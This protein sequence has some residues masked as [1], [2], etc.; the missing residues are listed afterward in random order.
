[1][2]DED[3]A[4]INDSLS[5]IAP[6]RRHRPKGHDKKAT[7]KDVRQDSRPRTMVKKTS[8]VK[9][10]SSS[11]EMDGIESVPDEVEGIKSPFKAVEG[12]KSED[13]EMSGIESVNDVESVSA[14][15]DNAPNPP[16]PGR[17]RQIAQ[18]QPARHV[19]DR[20]TLQHVAETDVDQDVVMLDRT[21]LGDQNIKQGYEAEDDDSD[22]DDDLGLE[23]Y[24]RQPAKGVNE[25][26]VQQPSKWSE[27]AQSYTRHSSFDSVQYEEFIHEDEGDD[28][29]PF[30]LV[31]LNDR[32]DPWYARAK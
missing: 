13:D 28:C 3:K 26:T 10:E 16:A 12:I 6:S 5:D 7:S 21:R 31:K 32:F 23:Q 1:M 9:I 22:S 30:D 25:R 8:V 17:P 24:I 15:L 2:N 14:Q 18:P 4:F 29:K 20:A 19:D 27:G 11:D